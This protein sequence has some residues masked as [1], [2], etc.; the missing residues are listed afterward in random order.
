MKD[1]LLNV[2]LAEQFAERFYGSLI[3]SIDLTPRLLGVDRDAA[4]WRLF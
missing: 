2:V 1:V 4:T 3:G